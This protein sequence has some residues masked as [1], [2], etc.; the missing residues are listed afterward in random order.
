MSTLK[1]ISARFKLG[2]TL[3]L[4]ALVVVWSLPTLGLLI[5]S[6]RRRS[7][8]EVSPW[9]DAI[10]DPLGTV[11][12]TDAYQTALES[13]MLDALV[14]TFAVTIPATI[15]PLMVAANAAY[16]FTFLNFKGKEVVFSLMVGLMVV[17]LQAALIPVLRG[18][19]WLQKAVD[20]QLTGTYAS[21]WIVHSAFAMPLAIYIIRNY[22]LTIPTS[23]IEAARIDGASY[24]KIFWSLVLPLSMPAIAS[25]AIFQFLWVWNDYLIAFIFVGQGSP[26]LTYELLKLLGQ[27]GQGW[28]DVAAGAFI[29]LVVPL[30][31]FLGLQRFFVRGLTSG[32]VK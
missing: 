5:T 29:S 28:Q 3:T 17:P 30:L 19:V 23:L 16:A 2:S 22:M 8:A 1:R 25:F 20:I 27:Y 11:W 26:V 21:A 13:G 12:S 15:L 18:M 7:D 9:W 4:L 24:Y 6:L 32:S 31:V 10:F 14:N